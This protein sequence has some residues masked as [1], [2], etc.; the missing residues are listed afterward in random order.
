MSATP[1]FSVVIPAFDAEARIAAAMRSVL[2]Q[3]DPDLELIVVD[4]GSRDATAQRARDVAAGDPRVAV[5]CKPNGG[6]VSARNAGIEASAGKYI[7]LLD[8][9]DLLLPG[10][11]ESVRPLLGDPRVG[12]VHADAWVA[13]YEAGAVGRRTAWQ[14]FAGP[15]R[16][17]PGRLDPVAA[18]AALLR[19]N[20]ITTCACVVSRKAMAQ[21]GG[22]DPEIVGS[23]DWDLWLRIVGSGYALA[24]VAR[25]GAVLRKRSDSVG[26]D[27]ELMT[28]GALA[29]L[30][31][32]RARGTLSRRA[33]RIAARH[34]RVLEFELWTA[35]RR[36]IGGGLL[37]TT[38]ALARRLR[39][40]RLPDPRGDRRTHDPPEV[41]EALEAAAQAARS[42]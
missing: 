20:F 15:V 42:A 21:S 34:V 10:H 6:T 18:E 19:I 29:V 35:H 23:D 17:L 40:K 27:A 24:R 41:V 22:L 2:A 5:I 16:H 4:D 25:P 9:D 28:R 7:A 39:R 33:D 14:R 8:D 13:D 3:S 38:S 30:H 12:I 1:T 26:S 31:K 11:L 36:S 37:R 32:A